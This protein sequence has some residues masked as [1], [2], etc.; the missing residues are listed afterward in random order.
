MSVNLGVVDVCGS[1]S[2]FTIVLLFIDS[3]SKGLAV[4]QGAKAAG[5]SKI[6]VVDVNS[7]KFDIAKQLGATD[8]VNPKDIDGPIQQHIAG[9]MTK[10]G[11]DYTFDCTGST[12]VMRS[13][14]ECECLF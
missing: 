13:A 11:V 7:D 10:W 3:Y 12:A 2:I 8:C 4:V 1:H 6:I 5:A 14:L 9:T